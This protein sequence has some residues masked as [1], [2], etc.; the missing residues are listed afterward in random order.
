MNTTASVP[1]HRSSVFYGWRVVFVAAAGL[2]WGV[3]VTV[4]S[5]PVFLKPLMHEFHTGRAEISLAFTLHLFLGAL[6]TPLT[7]WLIDR[8]GTRLVILPATALYGFLL[9]SNKVFSASLWHFYLFYAAIGVVLHGSGVVS[10]GYVVCHWFDR[11]RGLALGLMMVGI[12]IGALTMPFVAQRLITAYGWQS[13]YAIFG[14]L[15]LLISLPLVAAVLKEKPVDLGL[16]PDGAESAPHGDP[17]KDLIAEKKTRA[18][19]VSAREAWHSGAFWLMV[20]AFFLVSASVQGCLVHTTAML[21]DRGVPL[22][23]AALASSLIGVAVLVGRV[24]TGYLLDRLFAPH[25]AA[26]FFG[27][28]ALGITFFGLARHR[29][30]SPAPSL[31]VWGSGQKLTSSPT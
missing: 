31:L 7:G 8:F 28:V 30:R 26:V 24:G 22:Q 27:G 21:S 13:A 29:S 6:S 2:F 15:V 1:S 16:L 11:R 14:S 10:Y 17:R 5:F 9:L 12:G 3:P 19:G 18:H 4:Y 23:T 25:L 20:C